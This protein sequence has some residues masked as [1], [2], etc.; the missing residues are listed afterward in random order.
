[1]TFITN[2]SFY[3]QKNSGILFPPKFPISIKSYAKNK[4]LTNETIETNMNNLISKV[5]PY[6]LYQF[7]EMSDY[8]LYYAGGYS[9]STY[10]KLTKNIDFPTADIDIHYVRNSSTPYDKAQASQLQFAK[11]K[12]LT[13]LINKKLKE[14]QTGY[15]LVRITKEEKKKIIYFNNIYG[16]KAIYFPA[17]P[18]YVYLVTMPNY[19]YP[20]YKLNI[21]IDTGNGR[22]IEHFMEIFFLDNSDTINFDEF[23]DGNK[24][25]EIA[26][27]NRQMVNYIDAYINKTRDI[28][29]KWYKYGRR[30]S[31]YFDNLYKNIS[32]PAFSI[33]LIQLIEIYETKNYNYMINIIQNFMNDIVFREFR[34][35]HKKYLSYRLANSIKAFKDDNEDSDYYNDLFSEEDVKMEQKDSTEEKIESVIATK[36]LTYAQQ[37]RIQS[38]QPVLGDELYNGII[39]VL[40]LPQAN[41]NTIR[42]YIHTYIENK[43]TLVLFMLIMSLKHYSIYKKDEEYFIFLN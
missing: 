26:S 30:M 38:L 18:C 39:S 29:I 24:R 21:I 28:P 13:D 25:V 20:V 16:E 12:E 1:M 37:G 19:A 6:E 15:D 7:L 32:S 4:L 22:S 14:T 2:L 23:I 3:L 36:I 43:S 42:G 11:C 5:D 10:M 41:V 40:S 9:F 35:Y 34:E 31:L 27:I 17:D 8:D 33:T